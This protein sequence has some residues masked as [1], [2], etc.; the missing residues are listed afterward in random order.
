MTVR[1]GNSFFSVLVIKYTITGKNGG[2][3]GGL[4]WNEKQSMAKPR[5]R[6]AFEEPKT[7]RNKRILQRLV[8]CGTKLICSRGVE[9]PASE[10]CVQKAAPTP[11]PN[12][13]VSLYCPLFVIDNFFTIGGGCFNKDN[14]RSRSSRVVC[15]SSS[16]YSHNVQAD[17]FKRF[18]RH[19]EFFSH[20]ASLQTVSHQI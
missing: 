5:V 19:L 9:K 12:R 11:A 2:S 14:I 18:T 15:I 3:R 10:K 13:R 17:H 1:T 16:R 6:L 8:T 7:R 20:P 4:K